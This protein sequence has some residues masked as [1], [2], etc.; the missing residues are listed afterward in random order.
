MEQE[1][2]RSTFALSKTFDAATLAQA[3][4][5]NSPPSP[6]SQ[7]V[8]L[9]QKL[10]DLRKQA[11]F[12]RIILLTPDGQIVVDSEDSNK[13]G[14]IDHTLRVDQSEIEQALKQG[15]AVS[16]P[17]YQLSQEPSQDKS[18]DKISS[19]GSKYV[20]TCYAPIGSFSEASP[21]QATETPAFLIALELP[22]TFKTKIAALQKAE[23]QNLLQTQ[24]YYREKVQQFGLILFVGLSALSLFVAFTSG[25][26]A[27]LFL[28]QQK[29]LEEERRKAELAHFS[30]G[31]AHEIKN[32]LAAML[33]SLQL[34]QRA[35]GEKEEE[36][37]LRLENQIRNLDQI[38]KDFLIFARGAQ[39]E[40]S[41]LYLEDIQGAILSQ[42]TPSQQACL[43]ITGRPEL[44]WHGNRPALVQA[45]V[46]LIKNAVEA[47][48]EKSTRNS[49]EKD[50]A[51][52]FTPHVQLLFE[53]SDKKIIISIN[54]N[55][56]GIPDAIKE[57]LFEPFVS[58]KE[59]GT[60]LGLA[61]TQRLLRDSGATIHLKASGPY[62]TSFRIHIPKPKNLDVK[63]NSPQKRIQK[64][65]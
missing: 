1:L 28:R 25:I 41:L 29:R 23:K 65:S 20:K 8:K 2:E 26:F 35:L 62:G 52:P 44:C 63:N 45:L 11:G 37:T 58:R 42:L 16:T 59:N 12:R 27:R 6:T 54:D 21:T 19:P 3:L 14:S 55:G 56:P 51:T 7:T 40:E 53:E 60:G 32:P 46:N 10:Q 38:V 4:K 34:L 24:N 57:K 39:H 36:H 18:S 31:I 61:I 33:S 13:H 43:E 47:C 5:E 49:Q 30:A 22:A 9:F 50:Q 48:F 17:L 15:A 64:E